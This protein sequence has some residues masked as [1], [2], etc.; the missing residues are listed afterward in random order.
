MIRSIGRLTSL[1]PR[2]SMCPRAS[3][4]LIQTVRS[5][6]EHN[7]IECLMSASEAWHSLVP[8]RQLNDEMSL[9]RAFE[10]LDLDGNGKIDRSELRIALIAL[11]GMPAP[12]LSQALLDAQVDEMISWADIDQDGAISWQEYEK[13]VR[14]NCTP[15]GGRANA[16]AKRAAAAAA[17]EANGQPPTGG[18]PVR[19][20]DGDTIYL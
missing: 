8:Q 1:A 13:I 20:F 6:R 5:Y 12:G 17:E 7:S 4:A 9:R 2:L 14:Y 11:N 19:T 3:P 15:D 16:R 10:R 18:I